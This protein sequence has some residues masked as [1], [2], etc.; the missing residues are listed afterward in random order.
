MKEQDQVE[1]LAE[2][3]ERLFLHNESRRK[4]WLRDKWLRG[5]PDYRGSYDAIIPLRKKIIAPATALRVKWLNA[6]HEVVARRVGKLVSD[7][8]VASMTTE[9]ECETLLR[10]IGKWSEK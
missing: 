5:L 6:A 9:E 1:A 7:F 3:D 8:D 2:L 4:V 10:A